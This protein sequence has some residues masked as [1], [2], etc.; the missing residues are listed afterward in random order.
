MTDRP[1]SGSETGRHRFVQHLCVTVDKGRV[2]G[3]WDHKESGNCGDYMK[4]RIVG[5]LGDPRN[6]G[7]RGKCRTMKLWGLWE[8]WEM[9]SP[10]NHGIM[11]LWGL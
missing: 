10:G 5:T 4:H 6:C 11:E 3:Q 8:L 1:S 9:Q 7:E 2:W